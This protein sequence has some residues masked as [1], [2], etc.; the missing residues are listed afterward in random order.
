M[1]Q[2][3]TGQLTPGQDGAPKLY[4]VDKQENTIPFQEKLIRLFKAH[5]FVTIKN[6]DNEPVYW[7][8]MPDSGEQ[9]DFS[10]DGLQKHISREQPEMWMINPGDVE[11]IVGASAYRALDVMYKN[12]TSKRVLNRF[13]DPNSQVYDEKG[14]HMPRNFNFADAGAQDAFIQQA[15]LGKAQPTFAQNSVAAP[16]PAEPLPTS[17]PNGP[18]APNNQVIAT[19]ETAPGVK[20]MTAQ[21]INNDAPKPKTTEGTPVAPVTYAEPEEQPAPNPM[22]AAKKLVKANEPAKA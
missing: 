13:K 17:V 16:A 4:G 11:V 8:Y 10:E 3:Q 19:A 22:N 14:Q 20:P 7:Q 15:Y 21:P 1:P 18:A 5:E 12:V 9:V 2:V 6:I